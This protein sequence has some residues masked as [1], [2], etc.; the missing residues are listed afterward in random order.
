MSTTQ[1]KLKELIQKVDLILFHLG[2]DYDAEPDEVKKPNEPKAH[3]T[4]VQIYTDGGVTTNPGGLGGWGAVI[5]NG[6]QVHEFNGSIDPPTTNNR[7][8]M[9]A[10]LEGLL[11]AHKLGFKRL[12]VLSDSEYVVKTMNGEYRKRKNTDLW[13][14][15]TEATKG[16]DIIYQWVKGHSGIKYNEAADKLATKAMR[17]AKLK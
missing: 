5:V 3:K 13:D 17:E 10:L 8:E 4:R 9:T 14:Q 2:I 7:A 16:L 12:Q 1:K 6:D 11:N 15:I